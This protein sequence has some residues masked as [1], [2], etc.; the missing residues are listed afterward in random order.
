[1]EAAANPLTISRSSQKTKVLL[2]VN[3][4]PDVFF[5]HQQFP[6]SLIRYV[7]G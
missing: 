7:Y 2:G 1:V 6:R 4:L 3:K 5:H